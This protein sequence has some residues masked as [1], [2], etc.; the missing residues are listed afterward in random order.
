MF[1]RWLLSSAGVGL[2]S[3]GVTMDLT[4]GI[5][6]TFS[7]TIVAQPADTTFAGASNSTLVTVSAPSAQGD[8]TC[9]PLIMPGVPLSCEL[10]A[11]GLSSVDYSISDTAGGPYS[12]SVSI[13]SAV[14]S[15]LGPAP[16]ML[17]ISTLEAGSTGEALLFQEVFSERTLITT[18]RWMGAADGECTFQA[19]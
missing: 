13:P 16:P 14:W 5:P 10:T 1:T 9:P 6:G 4:Y 2:S 8:L 15:Q 11:I 17:P 19:S 12:R 7:V 3:N 18:I